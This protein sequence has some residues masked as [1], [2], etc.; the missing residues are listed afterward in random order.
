MRLQGATRTDPGERHSRTGLPP[1]VINGEA[2]IGP[3]V[4]DARER[5]PMFG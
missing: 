2:L 5:Q 4:K 3:R 1:R